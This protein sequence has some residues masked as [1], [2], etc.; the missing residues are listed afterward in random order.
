MDVLKIFY[1]IMMKINISNLIDLCINLLFI[2]NNSKN[3]ICMGIN[4]K[5]K[6]F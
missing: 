5:Q 4:Y 3:L 1:K 2:N 6:Y